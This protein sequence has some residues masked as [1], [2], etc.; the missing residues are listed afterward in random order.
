MS[1][2]SI[3]LVD[4]EPE[5]VKQFARALKSEKY[6]V[7]TAYS[8]EEAWEKYQQRYYDVVIVDWLLEKMNGME[9]LQKIDA[10]HPFA[11][12]I[13]ITAFGDEQTAIEAHH[14]HAFDY[15]K[16]PVDMDELLKKV[17]EA[18]NRKDGV[19]AALENWVETHPD[20]AVR[21][22]KATLSGKDGNQVWSAK[23]IL[24][25]I[26]SNSERGKQEYQ[27]LIQLTIDLLTRGRVQ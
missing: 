21:P 20:D 10:I 7:D 11:K 22:L 23:E 24:E 14:F 13:M 25:E 15:L 4:D 17:K 18:I 12:V 16:K 2:Y 9:L 5:I 19:I 1:E 6:N 26:K 3:L 27:K 8:G